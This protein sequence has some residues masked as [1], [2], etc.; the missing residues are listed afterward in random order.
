[1]ILLFHFQLRGI[2]TLGDDIM[3]YRKMKKA[4]SQSTAIDPYLEVGSSGLSRFGGV[5]SEE[6]LEALKSLAKS[7]KIYRE[8]RDNDAIIGAI[9]F[10]I[11][12]LCRQVPWNVKA[13]GV[14][15]QA[16]EKADFLESCMQD[17]NIPFAEVVS[18]ILSMLPY[19][20]ALLEKVYKIRSGPN[21]DIKMRSKFTDGK[22]GWRKLPLRSQTSL[23]EWQYN[24]E[25]G[26]LEAM[27]QL[28]PITNQKIIIPMAKALHFR[29]E[30]IKDNPQ[31][32]SYLRNCYKSYFYASNLEEIEAIGIEHNAL[33]I[34]VGWVPTN[35]FTDSS[36]ASIKKVYQDAI[37]N[38]KKNE[39]DGLLFPLE[40]DDKG[41]KKYDLQMIGLPN[42]SQATDIGKVIERYHTRIAQTLMA[43]FIM[44][45]TQQVG[46]FA[47]ASN[48][49]ALFAIALGVILDII[50]DTFNN[51]AVVELFTLNGDNLEELPTIEHGDIESVDLTELGNYI[52][53]LASSGVP[54]F[55]NNE[56]VKKL[57][58]VANLPEPEEDIL[59]GI[60]TEPEEEPPK[61]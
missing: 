43:E 21:P 58:R 10:S 8:M 29:T 6:W 9:F 7:N 61:E 12:M 26:E 38:M 35:L 1:M 57:M 49:T 51:D 3:N 40:Y 11:D 44:L 60:S 36:K 17:L 52:K 31:G 46:S 55:P 28:D 19:G 50:R 37:E 30:C 56:L 22:I 4:A 45:G 2:V 53:S 41:H 48:K 47:L 20:W 32:R 5:I 54:L 14:S 13:G 25:S 34:L 42:A 27:I 39:S 24:K 59:D 23:Y 15:T 18:S 33:G 16:L